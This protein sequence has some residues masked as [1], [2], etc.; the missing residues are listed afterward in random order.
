MPSED[1]RVRR[2]HRARLALAALV[3]SALLGPVNFGQP[4]RADDRLHQRQEDTAN[5]LKGA[6]QNF[7]SASKTLVKATAALRQARN[8]LAEARAT[9]GT[10][11]ADLTVAQVANRQAQDD[12]AEANRRLSDAH[13]RIRSSRARSEALQLEWKQQV[14]SEYE[15]GGVALGALSTMLGGTDPAA[16]MEHMAGLDAVDDTYDATLSRATASLTL[17]DVFEKELS[18]AQAEVRVRVDETEQRLQVLAAA[19]AAAEEARDR[20]VGLVARRED[21]AATAARVRAR[22]A[23]QVRRLQAEQ[24]GIERLLRRR[25]AAAEAKAKAAAAATPRDPT[26]DGGW[27]WPAPGWV[28]TPFGWRTHPIY[29]YRSFHNG[30]D[31]AAACGTPVRAPLAGT[32]LSTYFQSAYGNRVLL[33]HGAPDGVGTATEYNHL[34]R[35]VVTPRQ[36]VS[37]GQIVGYVGNTGWSTGCHLHFTTYRSGQPVDPLSLLR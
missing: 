2:D 16:L 25:A 28:S 6:R 26:P 14:V 19:E 37:R 4:A 23:V 27:A 15:S 1:V 9:L 22:D 12:L 33:D 29:G 32:V 11:R 17:L 13:S 31:I 20:V 5:R 35:W 10:R 8:Q 36:R 7:D 21:A 24:A 34:Q 3:S 30:I 18:V